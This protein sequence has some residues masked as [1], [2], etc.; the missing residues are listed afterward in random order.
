L[1]RRAAFFGVRAEAE[2]AVFAFLALASVD[3][4]LAWA[5]DAAGDA[6]VFVAAGKVGL[7][8]VWVACARLADRVVVEFGPALGA[9]VSGEIAF[10]VALA[11]ERVA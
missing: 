3:E 9:F 5:Y 11:G 7:G 1:A 4:V 8:A 10:A 2:V 6:Q